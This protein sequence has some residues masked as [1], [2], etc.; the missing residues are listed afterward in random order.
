MTEPFPVNDQE[1]WIQRPLLPNLTDGYHYYRH[2]DYHQIV[3]CV[4]FHIYYFLY[5]S[6]IPLK[7][8]VCVY[9]NLLNVLLFFSYLVFLLLVLD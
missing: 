8:I 7:M 2:Y 3:H 6:L 1:R 9:E 5:D 4:V